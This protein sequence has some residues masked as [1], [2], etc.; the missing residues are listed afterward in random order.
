MPDGETAGRRNLLTRLAR[1][2]D[3]HGRASAALRLWQAILELDPS[4]PEATRR[5]RALGGLD[6]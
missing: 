5:V 2:E 4:H 1:L 3:E 6:L